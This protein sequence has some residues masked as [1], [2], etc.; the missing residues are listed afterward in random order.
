MF[1]AEGHHPRL[2]TSST[3]EP[4]K[5]EFAL[6]GD[7]VL[8]NT[9]SSM[10]EDMVGGCAVREGSIVCRTPSNQPS[11]AREAPLYG[12]QT[13]SGPVGLFYLG[14]TEPPSPQGAGTYPRS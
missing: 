11:E 6:P 12:G 8:V 2:I 3:K 14:K 7:S 1:E 9:Q 13:P 10:S 4:E 5:D